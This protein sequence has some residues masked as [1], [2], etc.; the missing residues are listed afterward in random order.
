MILGT[1]DQVTCRAPCE[2]PAS[3]S[4]CVSASLCVSH[5]EINKIFKK[6]DSIYLFETHTE[7]ENKPGGGE[8]GSPP[9]REP[10]AGLDPGTLG[11]RPEL[12]ADA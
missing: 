3:P 12:K 1:R 8:T 2:E 11:S 5:E 4:A 6:K 9:S 10:N 7:R